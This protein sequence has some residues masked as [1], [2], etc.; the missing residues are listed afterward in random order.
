MS[1]NIQEEQDIL[2]FEDRSRTLK[3]GTPIFEALFPLFAENIN[4]LEEFAGPRIVDKYSEMHLRDFINRLPML[5]IVAISKMSTT[6][7]QVYVMQNYRQEVEHGINLIQQNAEKMTTDTRKLCATVLG[8]LL[9][10]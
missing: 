7:A 5:E 4:A 10:H 8:K 2:K 6:E 9:N 3:D 1:N